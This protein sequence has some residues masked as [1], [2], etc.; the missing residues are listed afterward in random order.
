MSGRLAAFQQRPSRQQFSLG[1][2]SLYI[3]LVL[4]AAAS[5]RCASRVLELWGGLLEL[6]EAAPSWYTGRLWLL[7]VGYYKLTR[8]KEQAPDWVWIVDKTVQV[9]TGKLFVLLGRRPRAPAP[10]GNR[11][12]HASCETLLL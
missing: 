8:P 10:R 4:S 5:L 9:G 7:R 6:P 1:Q 11:L 12:A 2:I 3:S